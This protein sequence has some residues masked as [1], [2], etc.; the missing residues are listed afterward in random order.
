MKIRRRMKR[1]TKQ[2]IIVAIICIV[3]IGGAAACTAAILTGEVKS[4]YSELLANAR[5]EIKD[6]KKNIYVATSD[7]MAGDCVTVSNVRR[8]T[9]FAGQPEASYIS[10]KDIGK[11]ALVRI[12]AGTQV[13]KEM[14]SG[15]VVSSELRELEYTV[16]SISKKV[17]NNDIVDVRISYPNG[18]NYIVLSKK[19]IYGM[20]SGKAYCY[21]QLNEEEIQLMSSAIV[22][23]YLYQGTKIFTTEYIQPGMQK[24]ST[25]DYDPSDATIN[26]IKNSPNIVNVANE[27][28]SHIV[29]SDLESR[30]ADSKAN[31]TSNSSSV[32]G[33]SSSSAATSEDDSKTDSYTDSYSTDE[34]YFY[35]EENSTGDDLG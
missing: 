5:N 17:D 9:V 35:Q 22:D 21:F 13:L 23:A 2:Y 29:R 15:A 20:K 6:N 18:E 32:S 12:T 25:V 28:L 34:S 26:R 31:N 4:K 14:L 16:I 30:L 8:Q 11:V 1:S 10:E 24:A 33:S 27:Y 3:V 19:R 7:I